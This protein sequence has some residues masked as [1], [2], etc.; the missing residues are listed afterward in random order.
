MLWDKF[1]KFAIGFFTVSIIITILQGPW[2]D[3]AMAALDKLQ[4]D[5]RTWHF[6]VWPNVSCFFFCHRL[7]IDR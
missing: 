1:P 7:G 4:A 2:E 6:T 5:G 3:E